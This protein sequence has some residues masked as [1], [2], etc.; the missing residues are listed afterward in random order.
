[1]VERLRF[2]TK[3]D[4]E[5]KPPWDWCEALLVGYLY[6]FAN[7]AATA[8]YLACI[9]RMGKTSGLNSFGMMWCNGMMCAPMLMLGTALTGELESVMA[10]PHI[11]QARRCR[12]TLSNPR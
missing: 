6:V 8:V 12:L 10:F 11:H 4:T 1:M 2:D 9:S 3:H 5:F 7:N